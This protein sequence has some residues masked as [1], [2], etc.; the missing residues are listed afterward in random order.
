MTLGD[1]RIVCSAD[2]RGTGESWRAQGSRGES[3]FVKMSGGPAPTDEFRLL[4]DL[5]HPALPHVE[6]CGVTDGKFWFATRWVEG[7]SLD[8]GDCRGVEEEEFAATAIHALLYL[9]SCGIVHGDVHPGNLLVARQGAPA[10]LVDFGLA[11]DSGGLH[12]AGRPGFI[13]PEVRRGAPRSFAGDLYGLGASLRERGLARASRVAQLVDG[14][15]SADL[16]GR[17]ESAVKFAA[18]WSRPACGPRRVWTASAAARVLSMIGEGPVAGTRGILVVGGAGTGKTDLL[19]RV[20]LEAQGRGWEIVEVGPGAASEARETGVSGGRPRLVMAADLD[21]GARQR[22]TLREIRAAAGDG[23]ACCLVVATSRSRIEGWEWDEMEMRGLGAAELGDVFR[24]VSGVEMLGAGDCGRIAE[25]SLGAPGRAVAMARAASSAGLL[26][27]E[28]GGWVLRAGAEIPVPADALDAARRRLGELDPS[29]AAGVAV[30]ALAGGAV[31]RRGLQES[32]AVRGDVLSR[33]EALGLLR[34]E[35]GSVI[36]Q[37]A[38]LAGAAIESFAEESCRKAHAVLGLQCEREGAARRVAARHWIAAGEPELAASS[39]V[40]GARE[41]VRMGDL[42]GARQLVSAASGVEGLSDEGRWGLD[43][44]LVAID[45]E[46]RT[47]PELAR[48]AERLALGAPRSQGAGRM[49]ALAIALW[50][51]LREWREVEAAAARL[52]DVAGDWVWRRVELAR[53]IEALSRGESPVTEERGAVANC[54]LAAE[55]RMIG[56]RRSLKG[57]FRGAAR[58]EVRALRIA[59]ALGEWRAAGGA[60][61]SAVGA[62]ILGGS[63][64]RAARV[65]EWCLA[66]ATAAGRSSQLPGIAC[67]RANLAVACGRVAF[68]LAQAGEARRVSILAGETEAQRNGRRG[69]EAT[70]L[71]YAGRALEVLPLCEPRPGDSEQVLTWLH[72]QRVEALLDLGRWQEAFETARRGADLFRRSG[73][74]SGA[75]VLDA[76]GVEALWNARADGGWTAAAAALPE[77]AMSDS[78]AA[79]LCAWI[80]AEALLAAGR[81]TEAERAVDRVKVSARLHRLSGGEAALRLAAAFAASGRTAAAAEL[82][83][84]A[85]PVADSPILEVWSAVA[86]A[87]LE[88]HGIAS[89]RAL[90]AVKG[91]VERA[92]AAGRRAWEEEWSRA[93]KACEYG[94]PGVAVTGKQEVGVGSGAGRSGRDLAAEARYIRDI[95]RDLNAERSVG[96]LL[97]KILDSA[98]AIG[99]AE[100]GCLVLVDGNRFEVRAARPE[101]AGL[102]GTDSFSRTISDKVLLSGDPFFTANALRDRRLAESSSIPRLNVHSVACVPF[103]LRGTTLGSLYLDHRRKADAFDPGALDALQTLADLAAVAIE[104]AQ[105]FEASERQRADLAVRAEKLEKRLE[106]V[107]VLRQGDAEAGLKHRYPAIVGRGPAMLEMLR[108]VDRAAARPQPVLIHGE[109]GTGKELVARALHASGPFRRGPFV[110]ENCAA[111]SPMLMESELFG[112]VRGAFSGAT[113]EHAGLFR[114]ADGGVLFLDEIG[115]LDMAMQAKLLRV[116]EDGEVRP[117]GSD[118]TIRVNVRVVTATHHDLRLL[119]SQGKFRSDLYYRLSPFRVDVPA[120][121]ERREDIPA[122]VRHF[123]GK[124]GAGEIEPEGMR[125]LVLARWPGNVRQLEHVLGVL[126]AGDDE[127]IGVDAVERVLEAEVEDGGGKV[128]LSLADELERLRATRVEAALVRAEGDLTRAAKELGLTYQGVRRIALKHKLMG[129]KELRASLNARSKS[130]SRAPRVQRRK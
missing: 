37:D 8:A 5:E 38:A 129:L 100:R 18:Q 121:R 50:A 52:C 127:V 7:N 62:L 40:E 68:G 80:R 96:P 88:Q 10:R 107:D 66:A 41:L 110:A 3:V 27:L 117:V 35:G 108:A 78:T 123:L 63:P 99:G 36:V 130:G 124:F 109:T 118:R 81:G 112:H 115:D 1:Y 25:L 84:E 103:R 39:G 51:R 85:E 29:L 48:A 45:S 46:L 67:A 114:R 19:R 113:A 87:R 42:H 72:T 90:E 74:E 125:R 24:Q 77:G 26:V 31:S 128:E 106:Q 79:G 64:E 59:V 34:S 14:L 76:R 71:R 61:E 102:G 12:P 97:E 73:D 104:N 6:G 11:S 4:A 60:V 122:L 126:C 98:I 33:L 111:I 15:V 65:L 91:K 101:N 44:E 93:A 32:G 17:I 47:D 28:D 21:W 23:G 57:D 86:R 95:V 119:V 105:L 89:R 16:G 75:A 49:A 58:A 83:S 2:S 120:L 9:R 22:E 70:L 30:I 20:R 116:L 92:G 43:A 94:G 56:Y 82:L 55:A 69:L 13:A 54:R 53:G